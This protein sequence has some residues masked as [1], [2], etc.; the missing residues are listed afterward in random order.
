[1]RFAEIRLDKYGT[2]E[3]RIIALDDH[4]GLTIVYGPNEAGK[5]TSLTA[6]TDLLYGMENSNPHNSTFGSDAQRVH[7]RLVQA[8]DSEQV[9]QRRRGRKNTL[10]GVDG[11]ALDDAA[12]LVM[13]GGQS[14]ARFETLFGLDHDRLRRG[15]DQLFK[16]DGDIGRLIVEA[17]GGLRSLVDR[18]KR[19]DEQ[20]D[21]LFST[22]RSNQRAFYMAL[23]VYSAA[24][25]SVKD[26][27]LSSDQYEKARK[28]VSDAQERLDS[29]T[30]EQADNRMRASV[31]ERIE[32]VT[33]LLSELD[34]IQKELGPFR[35]FESVA[36][37][38]GEDVA[39]ALSGIAHARKEVED[40]QAQ[41]DEISR[42]LSALAKPSLLDELEDGIFKAFDEA[43]H[44]KRARES[45]QNRLDELADSNLKLDTLR[46]LLGLSSDHD[47]VS[48]APDV[49]TIERAVGLATAGQVRIPKL[50]A[51][52]AQLEKLSE[53]IAGLEAKQADAAERG[54]D[55][56]LALQPGDIASL[57]A[58]VLQSARRLMEIRDSRAQIEARAKLLGYSNVA[59]L[60]ADLFPTADT[61]ATEDR[62]R[63]SITQERLRRVAQ[64]ADAERVEGEA[65]AELAVYSGGAAVASDQALFEARVERQAALEPVRN[66]HREGRWDGTPEA[67]AHEIEILDNAI[68]VAD[69]I[70][71][72]HASEA[73]RAIRLASA[74]KSKKSAF[75]ECVA[76]T[77]AIDELDRQS[78]ARAAAVSQAFPDVAKR[79]P[80]WDRLKAAADES[81]TIL[82]LWDESE[83]A[84][85]ELQ[86]ERAGLDSQ[87][88]MLA[89]A[90]ADLGLAP[91]ESVG[92][93]DRVRAALG[94]M[95]SHA[96]AHDLF[97]QTSASLISLNAERK[98]AQSALGRLKSEAAAWDA[99]W[100]TVVEK[101]GLRPDAAMESA[102]AA[103]MEWRSVKGIFG[104]IEITKR[105]LD[106]MDEDE[107]ALST[108]MAAIYG[109]LALDDMPA[110]PVIAAAQLEKQLRAYKADRA[111]ASQLKPASEAVVARLAKA[112]AALSAF[113][114]RLNELHVVLDAGPVDESRLRARAEAHRTY[115]S[116]ISQR[117]V[118]LSSLATAGDGK[119]ESELRAAWGQ[120]DIDAVRAE[121][122]AL[123][124][125]ASET[126]AG[127]L[128]AHQERHAAADEVLRMQGESGFNTSLVERES[129]TVDIHQ[130]VE[131]YVDLS[132][133]RDLIYE[134]IDTVR[135]NQ[136]DPL[137]KRAG[138][139]FGAMTEGA[140]S[141]IEADVDDKGNPVVVGVREGSVVAVSAM[142]D[143]TRDQL[144]L[145]FRLAGL[146]S[147]C[148]A[149]EPLPFIA[150]DILVHFD[151]A[152]SMATLNVLAAFGSM[153]QVL[154]FTHHKKIMEFGE[155]LAARGLARVVSLA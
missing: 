113:T 90:E 132:V 81:R 112:N 9:L 39:S 111:Q 100:P 7:A 137:L 28:A 44:A 66:A 134:A 20:I 116:I 110:D 18:L 58:L 84:S 94:M 31:L 117:Q 75:A 16:A 148:K 22:R 135:T 24:D 97:N 93:Q 34:R 61:I 13:L 78:G 99:E 41:S 85:G 124:Q 118:V 95:S 21:G 42:K 155:L 15:G 50:E 37:T 8:N 77:K 73:Q 57:P 128:T 119:P 96:V 4:K 121:V 12:M 5:S 122:A 153:T 133:A 43:G 98:S 38:F 6:I 143:G 29:L 46:D 87:L 54:Y 147:Y 105:R 92:V 115:Q 109:K 152:R 56:S 101:L 36:P 19:I 89:K 127:R 104:A 126:D 130:I 106:R 25:R 145:A 65:E 108:A 141:G 47:L 146:D 102:A 131:R 63:E 103:A 72:R 74:L 3:S 68:Q 17:G 45:R 55:R 138:E 27:L 2:F 142:S 140:F 32:R 80:E 69:D 67:R 1:M 64:R 53:Q 26:Q 51:A 151:D 136:Q 23:D 82:R 120:R 107:A 49:P 86:V 11:V 70:A 83:K 35:I 71:D 60:R 150:D 88:A 40:G 125:Q 14:R 91:A 30:K 144:Y 154:L 149:S 76:A 139:L 48:I 123:R 79:F 114:E 62:A 129:A 10:L 59:E 52:H 33:P